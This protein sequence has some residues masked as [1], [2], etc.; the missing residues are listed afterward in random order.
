MSKLEELTKKYSEQLEKAQKEHEALVQRVNQIAQL[1][2]Q[3]NG[4]IFALNE[5]NQPEPQKVEEPKA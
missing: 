4:A 3:L 5:A 2:Q 1:I